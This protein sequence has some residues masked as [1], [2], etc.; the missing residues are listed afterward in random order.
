MNISE[1]V[2]AN[3]ITLTSEACDCNPH[4]EGSADMDNYKVTLRRGSRRMTLH[5]SKGA[6]HHGAEPEVTE[7]LE[8]LSSDSSGIENGSGFEDWCGEYGY[9]S[10]S[11]KA[12]RIYKTCARQAARLRTFLGYD[13]Y[14]Q[15][16]WNTEAM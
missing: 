10:D 13:L 14:R 12:H 6:G 2:K 16:L 4:M 5:F 3:Q 7:V 11:R 1:F 15:L 8:C 9:N